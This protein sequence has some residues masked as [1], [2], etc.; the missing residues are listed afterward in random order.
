M[1]KNDKQNADLTQF[2]NTLLFETPGGQRFTQDS[3][4]L[5]NVWL[6]YAR[7]PRRPIDL[8]LTVKQDMSTGRAALQLRE[9]VKKLRGRAREPG[10]RGKKLP[11]APA[12]GPLKQADKEPIRLTYLPGQIAVRLY[13]D[14][15]MRVVLP[16][17]PWWKD[18][19]K[20]LVRLGEKFE[21]R[22]NKTGN[23]H[24]M[25]TMPDWSHFPMDQDNRMRDWIVDGLML[26]RRGIGGTVGAEVE[27]KYVRE[28]PV[29]FIWVVRIAGILAHL[30]KDKD[31]EVLQQGRVLFNIPDPDDLVTRSFDTDFNY[32]RFDQETEDTIDPDAGSDEDRI[33]QSKQEAL[34]ARKIVADEFFNLYQDWT[35]TPGD[36]PEKFRIWR[37]TR[38]RTAEL[39]V[40]HSALTVKADAARRLFDISCKEIHWAI[41]DSGI[42]GRHH[43]FKDTT[44]NTPKA[45]VDELP[46][47]V[48]RTLDFTNL[49]DL[50]DPEIEQIKPPAG[51]SDRNQK[52]PY[53]QLID[54]LV[55]RRGGA[56]AKGKEKNA[57]E[58]AVKEDLKELHRRILKGQD[59]DWEILEPLITDKAPKRPHNDHGTHVAGILGAD[60]IDDDDDFEDRPLSQRPRLMQ[61]ICPDIKLIDC[62]V[63]RDE[64]DTDEFEILAA[65]Q[66]LRWLNSRAGYMMVHGAN[67]SLSL[68]HEVRRFAC[69]QTPICVECN[70]AAALG[71]AIVVAAGNRGYELQDLQLTGRSKGYDAINITD[72]GNAEA[73]ITVGA[74]HRKRP[75]EYGVSF[76]SSRGPTGDGRSKPD[77]VAPGEKIKGPT[78]DGGSEFKDGTSMAAPHVSG[79]VAMLMARHKELI[80]QPNRV[81]EILCATAT[82]LKRDP[83]FQGHGLL[84]ILRALQ[85]N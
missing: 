59:I 22:N 12:L 66:F 57:I 40:N 74:T 75:H 37:V 24:A 34:E 63:F 83:Y 3:P 18:V 46:N 7:Q 23:G 71:M 53:H 19:V 45:K 28:L 42:D 76:F 77:L 43:A 44:V 84:D 27:A 11:G 85:S 35:R 70:E 67:L 38:N 64:G 25:R 54:D 51:A 72:P 79:A 29:D 60:W 80:G 15:L 58:K 78:P 55:A 52:A 32:R 10:K 13:F 33:K 14:E 6:A 41:I 49:R 56:S 82:D 39:A 1:A 5:A 68:A 4:I 69:G 81:K 47:R 48:D 50:L 17:T 61:G 21:R 20:L 62:R 30:A 65:I 16:L 73:V 36:Q 31:R 26:M 9:M 2:F 8:I